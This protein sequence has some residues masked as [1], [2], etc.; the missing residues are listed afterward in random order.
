MCTRQDQGLIQIFLFEGLETYDG[1]FVGR[2]WQRRWVLADD[3]LNFL[4]LFEDPLLANVS[5]S[6]H[7][8]YLPKLQEVPAQ[9]CDW[10]CGVRTSCGFVPTKV[11]Q[12][13]P[14]LW[15]LTQLK[16]DRDNGTPREALLRGLALRQSID[17]QGFTR[18]AGAVHLVI[19]RATATHWFRSAGYGFF[20]TAAHHPDQLL[21]N[22]PAFH[23]TTTQFVYD[24]VTHF[25]TIPCRHDVCAVCIVEL[26]DADE[27]ALIEIMACAVRQVTQGQ[28]PPGRAAR[29]VSGCAA[30][31]HKRPA[32]AGQGRAA[33]KVGRCAA[34]THKRPG[35]S[36]QGRA[37]RW[38]VDASHPLTSGPRSFTNELTVLSLSCSWQLS[39]NSQLHKSPT[40]L[41]CTH[42][43]CWIER[44]YGNFLGGLANGECPRKRDLF[45]AR[46]WASVDRNSTFSNESCKKRR[47]GRGKTKCHV[48]AA[49]VEL[50]VPAAVEWYQF[51]LEVS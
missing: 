2:E 15:P 7:R 29:K 48:C 42:A 1:Y 14:H 37:A 24:L 12:F 35:A 40:T 41:K 34:P 28:A 31:T 16:L 13:Y 33:R 22:N 21:V 39:R 3:Q 19:L 25:P 9:I 26:D 45:W 46:R 49:V 20:L 5:S 50:L 10:V 32:R 44:V 47:L 23:C 11:P 17:N 38:W 8:R 36:G 43:L 4:Q 18:H 27:R 6:L 51:G 30:P